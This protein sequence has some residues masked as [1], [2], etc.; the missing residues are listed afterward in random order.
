[1]GWRGQLPRATAIHSSDILPTRRWAG[2]GPEE[3]TLLVRHAT[4]AALLGEGVG[5]VTGVSM[6][7]NEGRYSPAETLRLREVDRIN[8]RIIDNLNVL[9]G[10]DLKSEIK[11]GDRKS[12]V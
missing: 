2:T 8:M 10:D 4:E 11:P 3:G 5:S 12:V 1:M 7:D 6:G 9:L